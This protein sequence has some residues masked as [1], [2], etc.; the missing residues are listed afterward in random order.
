MALRKESKIAFPDDY[1]VIDIETTGLSPEYDDIIEL[2]AIKVCNN[3]IQEQFSSLVQPPVYYTL[4]EQTHFIPEFITDLTGI[5]DDM[6][7]N[8]PKIADIL[9]DYLAFIDNGN[10]IIIGHNVSFDIN[11][12]QKNSEHNGF[13]TFNPSYVD[14]IRICRKLFPEKHHHRL[15]DVVDYL[16]I[17][18][19]EDQAHR[20]LY[21]CEITNSVYQAAQEKILKDFDSL[22]VFIELFKRKRY[23]FDPETLTPESGPIDE[24]NPFYGKECIFT[25]TLERMVR[26]EAQ[27]LVVNAGGHC[28]KNITKKTDFLILGNNDYCKSIKDRKSSKQKKAERLKL[29]GQDIEIIPENVF[30]QMLALDSESSEIKIEVSELSQAEKDEVYKDF[31]QNTDVDYSV[32]DDIKIHPKSESLKGTKRTKHGRFFQKKRN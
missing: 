27:Q 5:T 20:S 31:Y 32:L 14:T 1:T 3:Q 26:K 10:S 29:K 15:A 8:A 25:G 18:F 19:S 11:F 23:H 30:Y 12:I 9:P 24:T 28:G 16:G 7:S 4:D 17:P 13:P 2:S 21:D 6:V 22:D